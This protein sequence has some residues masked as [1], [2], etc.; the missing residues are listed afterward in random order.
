MTLHPQTDWR[1]ARLDDLRR[2]H[3][4]DLQ[5]LTAA[6]RAELAYWRHAERREEWILSRALAR[7][8]VCAYAICQM[9]GAP[10]VEI[11]SRDTLGRGIRP[12]VTIAGEPARI[13]LSISHTRSA[14]LVAIC[15]T[16]G[17][18]IG[19]DLVLKAPL[20]KTFFETWFDEH[21]RRSAE[22][23]VFA[24]CRLWAVKEAVYKAANQNDP[25][26]P[27]QIVLRG[28]PGEYRC[29]YRG[30]D[31]GDC[32]QITTWDCDDHV[33]ALAVLRGRQAL[34]GLAPG[35]PDI[36]IGNQSGI[37]EPLT[38]SRT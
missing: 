27:R 12:R 13:S 11:C 25:F 4:G 35:Q 32:C 38:P 3:P 34:D 9:S 2:T 17:V 21:E 10:R 18:A 1:Y 8:V 24:A 19:A 7:Q 22:V 20:G 5:D 30:V 14:A 16:P 29:S 23:E 36:R 28:A 37:S 6:E 33:A 31:L 26:S 15:T